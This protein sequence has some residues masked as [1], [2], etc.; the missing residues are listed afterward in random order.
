[1]RG[2]SVHRWALAMAALLASLS[3]VAWR[4]GRAYEVQQQL[5]AVR[6]ERSL[7]LSNQAQLKRDIR[8]LQSRERIVRVARELMGLRPPTGQVRVI[9]VEGP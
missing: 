8:V 9:R 4:Q 5:E 7:A 1:V 3:V 6:T 2:A